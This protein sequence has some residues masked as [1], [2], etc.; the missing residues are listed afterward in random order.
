ME[1]KLWIAIYSSWFFLGFG[2][3]SVYWALSIEG[4]GWA[5]YYSSFFD[6]M[7]FF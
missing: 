6:G 5:P 1:Q 4:L 7:E 3:F 2:H